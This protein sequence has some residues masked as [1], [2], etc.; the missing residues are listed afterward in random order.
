[1]SVPDLNLIDKVIHTEDSPQNKDRTFHKLNLQ[2]TSHAL[3]LA[4]ACNR[5]S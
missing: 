4:K 2:H 1:M 3:N 5:S